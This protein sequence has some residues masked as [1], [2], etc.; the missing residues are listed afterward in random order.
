MGPPRTAQ[1]TD[2]KYSDSPQDAS[3]REQTWKLDTAPGKGKALFATRPIKPGTLILSDPP[4]LT[5][6]C[7]TS[8]STVETDLAKALRSLDRD[9][10]RGFL[11]LHNNFPSEKGILS[12]II[13]SNGY[14][15]GPGS[16]VGGV[17]L[18]VSRI[19]HSC[20]PN[21]KHNWN[22]KLKQQTVYALS[23]IAEGEEITL[24]YLEGGASK[25]R[26]ATL[27]EH[28]H[29]DCRCNLC[30]LP[31]DELKKSDAL[32]TQ[33]KALDKEIGNWDSARHNPEKVL[34]NGKKLLDIM[35]EE[36]INDDRLPNLYWDIFQVVIMHGDQAR[37]SVFAKRYVDLKHISE[38]GDSANAEEV[39]PYVTEP[40]KHNNFGTT[41][42]WESKVKDVPMGLR[43]EGFE[44][45]LWR[46][47]I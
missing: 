8:M 13:R 31:P 32:I 17:F 21:A 3:E 7:I 42:K 27:K 29:F 38:G 24:S 47:G 5:T 1:S 9:S 14:P 36:G 28:F 19:N 35:K 10:Q 39:L 25:E 18:N 46:E 40:N 33:A 22:K 23:P 34:A 45:W 26:K 30:S 2:S 11:S 41:K 12:N 6:D 4:L 37:A 16:E 43:E 44:K 20:R 15:L